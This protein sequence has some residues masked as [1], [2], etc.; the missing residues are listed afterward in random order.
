MGVIGLPMG[1][2]Y[3]VSAVGALAMQGAINSFGTVTV[4][5]QTTGEKIRQLFT[6]PMESVGMAV[7]SYAGQNYGARRFDRIRAGIGSALGIQL[8]YCAVAWLA[9]FLFKGALVG[10][11]LGDGASPAITSEAVEYLSVI[12]CFFILHGSLMVFRN[13]LQGMG[14]SVQAIISGVGELAGRCLGSL[15]AVAGG[16]FLMICLANPLAWALALAYCA[17]LVALILHKHRP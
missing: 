12:S 7:A 2:E 13:T 17:T 5:A 10:F 11:V 16:G 8:A 14:H 1:F 6:L 15:A 9:I 4:T 3:S